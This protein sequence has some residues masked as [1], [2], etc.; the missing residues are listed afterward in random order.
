MLKNVSSG[1]LF[2]HAKEDSRCD[3]PPQAVVAFRVL[4]DKLL[5]NSKSLGGTT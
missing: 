5:V 1:L 3:L 2:G 4:Q